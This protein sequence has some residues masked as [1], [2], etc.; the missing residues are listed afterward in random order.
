[1]ENVSVYRV[2][3]HII[4]I[5]FLLIVDMA[6]DGILKLKNVFQIVQQI[7]IIMD[8]NV[9]AI[10]I[11]KKIFIINVCKSVSNIKKE[12]MDNVFVLEDFVEV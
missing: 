10:I 4:I 11:M 1:M 3:I 9:F 2:T 6:T 5:V 12:L 8:H 7:V